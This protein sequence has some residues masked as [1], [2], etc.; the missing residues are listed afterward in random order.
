MPLPSGYYT[1]TEGPRREDYV[2]PQ[3]WPLGEHVPLGPLPFLPPLH[4]PL[5]E[6]IPLT[7]YT[8][9]PVT[10]SNTV[11]R[12]TL[13]SPH[14]AF[15]LGLCDVKV[16]RIVG[17]GGLHI[18]AVPQPVRVRDRHSTYTTSPRK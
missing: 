13:G 2:L 18:Q 17:A 16:G 1:G 11:A 14:G 10:T 8:L 9:P 6:G 5:L 4:N 15:L 7:R 3:P 12:V